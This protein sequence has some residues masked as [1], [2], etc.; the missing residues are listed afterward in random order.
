MSDPAS[1]L[2]LLSGNDIEILEFRPPPV[3]FMFEKEIS[4]LLYGGGPLVYL[5]L[6]FGCSATLEFSIV[7]DSKGI[8]EAVQERQPIK[9]LNSFAFRDII[10]GVGKKLYPI[11]IHVNTAEVKRFAL[12]PN[13]LTIDHDD[14]QS[15]CH[16]GG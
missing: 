16:S 8:R 13:R 2:G 5:I 15:F 6:A 12:F 1:V 10:D 14:S 7:L 9:A 3:E 11:M 4:I